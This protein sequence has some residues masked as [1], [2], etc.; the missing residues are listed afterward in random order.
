M[1]CS[2]STVPLRVGIL[3]SVPTE[4]LQYAFLPWENST[5]GQV[6]DTY[7][8]L[9]ESHVGNSIFVQGECTF[10]IRHCLLV[11]RG[12]KL[13]DIKRVLSHTQALGQCKSWFARHI[14][15]AELVPIAST[16]LAAKNVAASPEPSGDA[17]VCSKICAELYPGLDVLCESIQDEESNKT[18]F[19][20]LSSWPNAM[21]P[22]AEYTERWR[23]LVR[24]RINQGHRVDTVLHKLGLYVAKM[25]RRPPMGVA[26]DN[27]F[28]EVEAEEKC[29]DQ[30]WS[31]KVEAAARRVGGDILG[32][33]FYE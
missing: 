28:I 10:T 20:V 2:N 22:K 8:A 9:R 25:D 6:I 13:A 26:G 7:D 32:I 19:M 4:T 33:W 17:A 5:H 1:R 27:Y 3:A 14:P 23:G 11:K 21:I 15:T 30:E 29:N 31:S 24:V 12:T 16:A 18:R